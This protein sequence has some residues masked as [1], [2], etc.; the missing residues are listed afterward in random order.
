MPCYHPVDAYRS[1]HL[2]NRNT[3]K[4]II[5]HNPKFPENWEL[6]KRPCGQCRGCRHGKAK[7]WAARCVHEAQLYDENS[8]ITLTYNNEHV[9]KN[10]SLNKRDFQLFMKR[11]RK[12]FFGNEKSTIRYYYCGEYGDELS[13]PHFHALLFNIDFKDKTVWKVE[14]GNTHYRSKILEKIWD[15]GYST[16]GPVTYSTAAYVARYCLKKITGKTAPDHYQGR[17]PEFTDMS[18]NPGIARAWY[19]KYK[20][21]DVFPRDYIVLNGVKQKVP[22]YYSRCYELTNPDEYAKLREDRVQK[23][24]DNPNNNPEMLIAAEALQRSRDQQLKRNYENPDNK[25]CLKDPFSKCLPSLIKKRDS[26]TR[27]KSRIV[28][29]MPFARFTESST[30]NNLKLPDTHPIFLSG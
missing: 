8:F 11:L 23:A 27:R 2:K 10:G 21:T 3:G 5:S 18:T 19:E 1:R 7:G 24:K 17:K 28:K 6:F 14:D 29:L 22:N 15:L 26:T 13:R 12:Y 20:N 9:P 4:F 30:A 25:Q 16:I